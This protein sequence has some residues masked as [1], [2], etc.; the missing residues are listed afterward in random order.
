MPI[1]RF[2]LVT[3]CSEDKG[4]GG[5][6]EAAPDRLRGRGLLQ[7]KRHRH[8]RRDGERPVSQL[9]VIILRDIDDRLGELCI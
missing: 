9:L 2:I 3:G 7:A 8:Q 1:V 6:D 5:R 4:G